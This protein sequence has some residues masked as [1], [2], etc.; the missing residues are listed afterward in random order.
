MAEAI[1]NLDLPIDNSVLMQA[2][3]LADRLNAKLVAAVG[4]HDTT[5]QW[6]SDGATSMT[7]WLR[8]HTRRSAR[9]AALCTKT[10]RRLR[11][12]PA[13]AAAY[14]DGVLSGGQVQAI[15]SNLK[16][17]T[18]AL[19][20]EHETE[21][22]PTFVSLSVGET[23]TA[24][25]SWAC[26]AQALL[27]DDPDQPQPERSLHLSRILDGR[28]ELSGSFDPEGGSVID[29]ALRLAAT[30][31][32]DGEPARNPAQRRGDALV[33]L[34]RWFLDHQTQRRGGRHRPHLNVVTTLDD[35]ERRGQGRL[36]DGTI[37]GG[38]TVQRLF[39][40][41]GVHRVFVAG[42]S[43]IL[44]YGT[45]TRTVPAN[46]YNALII[47]DQHCRFPGCDR[48][49][50]WTEAHHVRWVTHGG[51]T[52]LR[53]PRPAMLPA[54]PPAPARLGRQTPPRR[55]LHRDCARWPH[56]RRPAPR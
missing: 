20:A 3:A 47:R 30:D 1:G 55:H 53:Q 39:C 45:T 43:S 24:M 9:D 34:C 48:P 52:S 56:P 44:D 41:A 22:V 14:R 26:Q 5:E 38:T 25:Q 36:L 23:A 37:L 27:G 33:D 28:R 19:F 16:D 6:R 46:L 35:L 13:T 54:S 11:E 32:V 2:F 29:T 42:R 12:L 17:R 51:P 40:D 50:D 7:A 21:L 49:P 4:E 18:V 15:V 31:D 10:A 8:H